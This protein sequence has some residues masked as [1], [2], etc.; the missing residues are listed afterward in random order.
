MGLVNTHTF[1]VDHG[2]VT[3]VLGQERAPLGCSRIEQVAIANAQQLWPFGYRDHVMAFAAQ[4]LRDHRAM[5]LIEQHPQRRAA[6]RCCRPAATIRSNASSFALIQSSIS[7][8]W[9]A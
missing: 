1:L 2:E 8:R 9:A 3:R 7:A 5:L 4:D 6:A